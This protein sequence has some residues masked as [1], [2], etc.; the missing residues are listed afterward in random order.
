M[1]EGESSGGGTAE[2]GAIPAPEGGKSAGAD[3]KGFRK[4]GVILGNEV[5]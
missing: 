1:I 3:L 2:R 4:T 5:E